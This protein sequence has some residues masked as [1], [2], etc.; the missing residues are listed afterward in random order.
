M[1][2]GLQLGNVITC[3]EGARSKSKQVGVCSCRTESQQHHYLSDLRD[4]DN[5]LVA[6]SSFAPLGVSY[7]FQYLL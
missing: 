6:H 4:D 3:S 1:T 2:P 5:S 7:M